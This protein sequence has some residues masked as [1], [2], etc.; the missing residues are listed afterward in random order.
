MSLDMWWRRRRPR[1]LV[2]V[3]LI[4][5]LFGCKG[6]P[7]YQSRSADEW[8]AMLHSGSARVRILAADAFAHAPPHRS[9]TVRALLVAAN[10]ADAAVALAA[11][12][13]VAHLERDAT[14]ALVEALD[15]TNT[16]V[17]RRASE[18]LGSS[19]FDAKR[20]V[21]ALIRATFDRDDSVRTLSVQSL[22][23][24]S[25]AAYSASARIRELASQP[26]PQRPAALVALLGVDTESR[27]FIRLFAAALADTGIAVRLAALSV[28]PAAAREDLSEIGPLLRKAL[29]D[30]ELSVQIAALR[31][32]ASS[33][34][35]D[36]TVMSAVE[37]MRRSKDSTVRRLADSV[38]ATPVDASAERRTP[39][40]R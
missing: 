31:A 19:R 13:A 16:H 10:D 1:R 2:V 24:L 35:R 40:R 4:A 7:S 3:T 36:S 11:R 28:L 27:T 26:G 23:R 34:R 29:A 30:P 8:A 20:S 9:A 33:H 25:F 39:R 14:R 32:V 37:A 5:S 6:D 22:G 18:A 38:L 17:K 15:D 21:P 12:V